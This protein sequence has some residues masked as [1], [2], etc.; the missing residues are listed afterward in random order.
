[1]VSKNI[2]RC[3][4]IFRLS[5]HK[6]RVRFSGFNELTRKFRTRTYT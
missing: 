4:E 6:L 5:F 2:T 1:M 3:G